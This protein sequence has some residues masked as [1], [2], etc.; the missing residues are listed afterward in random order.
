MAYNFAAMKIIQ[1]FFFLPDNPRLSKVI[2]LDAVISHLVAIYST[3][4]NGTKQSQNEQ[5]QKISSTGTNSANTSDGTVSEYSI[6]SISTNS[7]M[8]II[9]NPEEGK[10]GQEATTTANSEEEICKELMIKLLDT[11]EIVEECIL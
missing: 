3:N 4:D 6:S 7:D 5:Q 1:Y 9:M 11:L 10:F 8:S 2:T